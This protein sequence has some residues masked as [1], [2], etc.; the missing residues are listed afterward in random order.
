MSGNTGA[1]GPGGLA[2]EEAVGRDLADALVGVGEATRAA[3]CLAR[4]VV[5]AARGCCCTSAVSSSAKSSGN[6]GGGAVEAGAGHCGG[7]PVR[8][9]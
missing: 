6:S 4:E 9:R 2:R 5:T 3:L 1:E 8:R 7:R